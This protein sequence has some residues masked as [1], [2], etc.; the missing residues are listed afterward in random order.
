MPQNVV[1]I[2]KKL[3]TGGASVVISAF[4]LRKRLR[5]TGRGNDVGQL[6]PPPI[7]FMFSIRVTAFI[8]SESFL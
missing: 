8:N 5:R 7:T 1:G 2:K 3:L 6:K 4:L